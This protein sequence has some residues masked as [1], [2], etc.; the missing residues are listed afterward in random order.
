[1]IAE[2]VFASRYVRGNG[3]NFFRN[4]SQFEFEHG[5]HGADILVRLVPY[6]E[7]EFPNRA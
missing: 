7:R 1:M 4:K 5:M 2:A 6:R 3:L